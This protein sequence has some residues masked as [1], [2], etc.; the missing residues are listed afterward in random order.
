MPSI[1]RQTH[2][3]TTSSQLEAGGWW[4]RR[5]Y[6][7]S[8][9]SVS[10]RHHN[11]IHIPCS[12]GTRQD[13]QCLIT[14]HVKSMAKPVCACC[15]YVQKTTKEPTIKQTNKKRTH[16]QHVQLTTFRVQIKRMSGFF[17]FRFVWSSKHAPLLISGCLHYPVCESLT[18]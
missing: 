14:R 15:V 11:N 16:Q 2:L 5:V 1:R 18:G 9:L 4:W 12:Y 13:E 7:R 17:S 3:H 6:R 8:W 10:A